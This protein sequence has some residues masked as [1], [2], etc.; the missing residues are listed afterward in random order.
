[1]KV[2]FIFERL[3]RMH[4][5]KFFFFFYVLPKNGY[6][7][8]KF[9]SLH[10][11][12]TNRCWLKYSRKISRKSQI[13]EIFYMYIYIYVYIFFFWAQPG[14]CGG[15]DLAN[16]HRWAGPS[17]PSLVTGPCQWPASL[18]H[19]RVILYACMNSAK[20]ITLPSHCSSSCLQYKNITKKKKK[21][22]SDCS[23]GFLTF[24]FLLSHTNH[25]SSR[26]TGTEK[27]V[28]RT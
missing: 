7:N 22:Q 16:L 6:F 1:M 19:A 8:T 24:S 18:P 26:Y 4:E 14:P 11:K 23:V 12:N 10:Y 25:A 15:L 27:D 20:V 5:N 17:Q 28:E 9:V 21:P 13:F 3:G 2:W